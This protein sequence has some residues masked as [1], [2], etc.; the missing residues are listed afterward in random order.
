MTINRN[1][2]IRT[3]R[4]VMTSLAFAVL[5]TSAFAGTCPDDKVVE[6]G[7]GQQAGA[8]ENKGVTDTVI[9][10]T[11]LINEAPKI[12]RKFRMR[13]LVMQPGGIVAWHSHGERPAI[14]YIVSGTVVEYRSTCAVPIVHKAGDVAAEIHTTSHWWKNTSKEPAVLLSTDILNEA[15]NQHQM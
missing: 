9:A 7:K 5:S 15:S 4:S 8:T 11:D 6:N 1:T 14:I 13:R 2:I 12:D 3:G 10:S